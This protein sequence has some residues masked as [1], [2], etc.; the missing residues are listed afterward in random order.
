MLTILFG[1]LSLIGTSLFYLGAITLISFIV[2]NVISGVVNWLCQSDITEAGGIKGVS[3]KKDVVDK[4]IVDAKKSTT[5]QEKIQQ[6]DALQQALNVGSSDDILTLA[7]NS[8]G[9]VVAGTS[10]KSSDYSRQS[11]DARD[12]IMATDRNGNSLYK[13]K[14]TA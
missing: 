3:L 14:I 5:D 1:M 12:Y 8:Q 11:D 2:T 10:F 9:D 7:Q 6:Y 13:T 4:M